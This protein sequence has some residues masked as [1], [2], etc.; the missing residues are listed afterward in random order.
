M[1][2]TYK[3]IRHIH[4]PKACEKTSY[5]WLSNNLREHWLE[6]YLNLTLDEAEIVLCYAN[7]FFGMAI[8]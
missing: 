3:Q 2:K 8:K 4:K 5:E 1:Y 6:Q 7:H